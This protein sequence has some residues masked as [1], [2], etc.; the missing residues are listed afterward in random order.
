MSHAA[1]KL[2]RGRMLDEPRVPRFGG[3]RKDLISPAEWQ[4]VERKAQAHAEARRVLEAYVLVRSTPGIE[5]DLTQM[6]A[7]QVLRVFGSVRCSDG[8]TYRWSNA[9]A[10]IVRFK[11]SKDA[12]YYE[13][14]E[15]TR[16][17]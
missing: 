12:D 2:R 11:T 3:R 7:E 10:S 16:Q 8:Y 9:Q 15:A 13:R 14:F 5:R 4:E 17:G 6:D 1:R